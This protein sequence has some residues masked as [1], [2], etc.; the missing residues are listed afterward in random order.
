[1]AATLAVLAGDRE[2]GTNG[3]GSQ[4][5]RLPSRP[6]MSLGTRRLC[7]G[8]GTNATTGARDQLVKDEY[9]K[10]PRCSIEYRRVT[11]YRAPSTKPAGDPKPR[12]T[13]QN[14]TRGRFNGYLSPA[15]RR[16]VR[17][18]VSTWVRS[19]M[20]YRQELK[21]RWDPGRAYPVAFALTLPSKQVHTDKE[22]TRACLTPFLQYLRRQ[23][24][25]EHYFW[26]AEAQENGNL[27][28]H[29]LADKYID[30]RDLQYAW[31]HHVNALGYVDRY[32]VTGDEPEA[33]STEI[34]RIRST[35]KDPATGKEREVDPVDY[36]LDY[37][38]DAPRETVAPGHDV[39]DPNAPRVL[40]GTYR[41]ADGS[42]GTYTTRPISGRVW[43]MSDKLRE[44]REPRCEASESIVE[45]LERGVDR[46]TVRKV[47][48]EHAVLFFGD[49][50]G[51]M[52][53]HNAALWQLVKGY[54]VHVFAW[55][56]PGQ[57]PAGYVAAHPP[58]DPRDL[59]IDPVNHA[60]YYHD[61]TEELDA[62]PR[63]DYIE[64]GE[65]LWISVGGQLQRYYKPSA[66]DRHP[67]LLLRHPHMIPPGYRHTRTRSTPGLAT[68]MQQL[69]TTPLPTT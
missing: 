69:S 15:T 36:L 16:Q 28:Y 65:P 17:R 39:N 63:W 6:S 22:I 54:Y 5:G 13:D 23:H 30:A 59:W 41:K 20:I 9:D 12:D 24:G 18:V 19:V 29:V 45:A 7:K 50:Q 26:R 27:H 43:G 42:K 68:L 34:H 62:E 33:P 1:M 40:V 60:Y 53:A 25:I 64:D 67:S 47:E 2:Q 11:F 49:V 31:N 10:T 55:L 14:L 32:I 37:L 44:V 21:K 8:S 38:L 56:Y 52:K 51:S 4:Q 35:V 48:K 58:R 57:L 61:D 66:V 3:E 46:G